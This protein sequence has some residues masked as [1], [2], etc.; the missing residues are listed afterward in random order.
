M[1]KE[2]QCKCCKEYWWETN[3]H[4]TSGLCPICYDYVSSLEVNFAEKENGV[5]E[6]NQI[7]P[8]DIEFVDIVYNLLK[9]NINDKTII[10]IDDIIHIPMKDREVKIEIT[11][12]KYKGE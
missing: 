10:L 12:H 6:E 11:S 1:S 7:M 2:I 4:S 9:N 3:I 8:P 5:E